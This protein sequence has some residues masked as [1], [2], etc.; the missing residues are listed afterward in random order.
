MQEVVLSAE[1]RAA[2]GSAVAR[3]LRRAGRVPAVV[4]GRRQ[5]PI[6]VVVDGRDLSAALHTEAGLNAII[7]LQVD[8]ENVTTLAREVQRNPLRGDIVHVDFVRISL[9]ESVEAE[10]G[11]EFVGVPVGVKESGGIVETIRNSV[12]VEALPA[13]IPSHITLDVSGLDVG[14]VLRVE[15]LP[16]LDGVEYLDEADT[17]LVTVM[18]PRA[19]VAEEE[20]AAEGEAL[21]AEGG[22]AAPVAAEDAGEE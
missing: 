15:D 17:T 9:T 12:M 2:Q 11:L 20:V 4:Y 22:E 6:P 10:V 3:R 19:A 21:E 14:D 7:T 13:S 16:V 1:R 18:V 8:G 5:D